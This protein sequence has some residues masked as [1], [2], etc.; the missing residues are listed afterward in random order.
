MLGLPFPRIFNIDSTGGSSSYKLKASEK[1]ETRQGGCVWNVGLCAPNWVP[2]WEQSAL[3]ALRDNI[4]FYLM[5]QW[6]VTPILSR[7]FWEARDRKG[8]WEKGWHML[9][10]HFWRRFYF[11][12][13]NWKVL[14]SS[15][16]NIQQRSFGGVPGVMIVCDSAAASRHGALSKWE[17]QWGSY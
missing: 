14:K 7:Y 16:M 15:D 1:E 12:M 10:I 8:G 9:D 13:F 4:T 2:L 5:C 3:T 11:I 6:K 17:W